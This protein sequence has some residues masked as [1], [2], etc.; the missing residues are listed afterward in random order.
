M[1]ELIDILE[2]R[3]YVNKPHLSA[4]AQYNYGRVNVQDP[5]KLL[6]KKS[7]NVENMDSDLYTKVETKLDTNI[8]SYPK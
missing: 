2:K 6:G 3:I 5:V 4:N 8:F 1:S 7:N